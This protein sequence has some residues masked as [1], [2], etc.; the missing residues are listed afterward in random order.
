MQEVT[1]HE[2]GEERT[3]R[4]LEDIRRRTFGRW[5]GLRY[6]SL[7]IKGIQEMGDELLDHVGALTLQDP[8]LDGAPGGWRCGRPPSARSV[9]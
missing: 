6:N 7:S 1:R 2:V 4:A 3:G 9:F 8:Q 5:H